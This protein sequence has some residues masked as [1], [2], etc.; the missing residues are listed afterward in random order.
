MPIEKRVE[1]LERQMDCAVKLLRSLRWGNPDNQQL[2]EKLTAVTEAKPV[3]VDEWRIDDN[4]PLP[5]IHIT[6]DAFQT[7]RRDGSTSH[8]GTWKKEW[9]NRYPLLPGKPIEVAAAGDKPKEPIKPEPCE[10][11]QQ[12]D[13]PAETKITTCW[14]CVQLHQ[15]IR[16][17]EARIKHCPDCGGSWIE[18]GFNAGCACLRIKELEAEVQAWRRHHQ[19]TA[20]QN[21][22]E[23]QRMVSEELYRNT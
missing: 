18:D 14:D 10:C 12:A 6:G 7:Y 17:L 16:E 20:E 5:F 1:K 13:M 8:C 3:E 22:R 19:R 11:C 21:A 23:I 9:N 2:I 4:A 15:R